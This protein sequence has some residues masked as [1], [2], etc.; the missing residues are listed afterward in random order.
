M[1]SSL[2]IDNLKEHTARLA[3]SIDV[4]KSRVQ[5]GSSRVGAYL[6]AQKDVDVEPVRPI[7]S[8]VPLI[9]LKAR[10]SNQTSDSLKVLLLR[11]VVHTP[12][13]DFGSEFSQEDMKIE[14]HKRSS[15]GKDFTS[16]HT[17]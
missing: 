11:P 3:E 13:S 7:E 1:T 5:I 16:P 4:I 8:Y 14:S 15:L 2:S 6:L 10:Y 9:I 12:S 17:S